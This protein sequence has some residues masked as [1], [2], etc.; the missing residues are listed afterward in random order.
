LSHRSLNRANAERESMRT[1]TIEKALEWL[2]GHPD[3]L[4]AWNEWRRPPDH[5]LPNLAGCDLQRRQ[6]RTA[7]LA[8]INLAGAN[9]QG[10]LFADVCLLGANLSGAN[11]Q[12]AVLSNCILTGAT[13]DHADLQGAHLDGSYFAG[14][15]L[16]GAT[17]C[18][19]SLDGTTFDRA[20]IGRCVLN[21][22]DLGPLCNAVDVYF[23]APSTVDYRSIIQSAH[24]PYLKEF[25]LAIGMPDVFVEY[26]VDCA[27][28]LSATERRSILQSSFISYGGNDEKFAIKLN[29]ALLDQGVTTFLFHKDAE[30]GARLSRVMHEGVRKYDR[31]I[32]V[33]SE[34]SLKRPGVLNEIQET[35]D[36]EAENGGAEYLI[37]VRL[38]DFVL[39]GWAPSRP[40]LA[41]AVRSRVVADFSDPAEFRTGVS[42][43][44]RALKK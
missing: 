12:G 33:C 16:T 38:D 32:L 3:G 18:R 28:S 35:L 24:E 5:V 27:H 4:L 8:N 19:A 11:L 21:D 14:A 20:R 39:K 29:R 15:S 17:L 6:L 1:I 37:P 40:H 42:R 22:L 43:L 9:L 13:L 30:L 36:R 44:I 31:V 34:A 23:G 26:N 10:V 25:L 7:N 41:S 2:T